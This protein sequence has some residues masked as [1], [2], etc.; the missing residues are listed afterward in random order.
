MN[1]EV[2]QNQLKAG[3]LN[4]INVK[5]FLHKLRTTW[6]MHLWEDKGQ[7]WSVFGWSQVTSVIPEVLLPGLHKCME[8]LLAK[9]PSFY[10][11]VEC[12]AIL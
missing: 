8:Q 5:H 10:T 1:T 6:M 4:H 2:T 3:R 11:N 12:C 7:S 9:L